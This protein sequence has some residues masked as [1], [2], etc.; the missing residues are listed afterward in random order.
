MEEK[1]YQPFVNSIFYNDLL[2][3][4]EQS[5]NNGE[6]DC[7][8]DDHLSNDLSLNLDNNLHV[9]DHST[10]AKKKL[11]QLQEKLN[12]KCQVKNLFY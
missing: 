1:Y 7:A 5:D 10:Y 3:A 4:M 8:L 6:V 2:K 9:G 12:N 11:D